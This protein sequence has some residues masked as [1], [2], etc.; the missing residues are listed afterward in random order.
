MMASTVPCMGQG[1]AAL[2]CITHSTYTQGQGEWN[3]NLQCYRMLRWGLGINHIVL[4]SAPDLAALLTVR[5]DG[6][7]TR[8]KFVGPRKLKKGLIQIEGVK[9][10]CAT[11]PN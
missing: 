6:S 4:G 5:Y 11:D 1:I 10:Q 7:S 2:H 8:S 9:S 3:S